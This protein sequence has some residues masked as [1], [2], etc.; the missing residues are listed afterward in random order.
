MMC[1]LPGHRIECGVIGWEMLL[2]CSISG[3]DEG[4]CC[5]GFTLYWV[6]KRV[7][8]TRDEREYPTEGGPP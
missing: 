3:Y 8:V 7:T 1:Q 4:V 6:H 2:S 5:Q